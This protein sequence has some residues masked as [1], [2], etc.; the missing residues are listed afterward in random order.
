MQCRKVYFLQYSS[1]VF[2]L[3]FLNHNMI[4]NLTRCRDSLVYL[5]NYFVQI[6]ALPLKST[7]SCEAFLLN[8]RDSITFYFI[9]RRF[10]YLLPAGLEFLIP[11]L[12]WE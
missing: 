10:Y 11:S 1:S 7:L 6:F 2:N 5:L 3:T 12:I 8:S 4:Q 9:L